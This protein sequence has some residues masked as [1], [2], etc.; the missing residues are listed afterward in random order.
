MKQPCRITEGGGNHFGNDLWKCSV[1][2]QEKYPEVF[3]CLRRYPTPMLGEPAV[4]YQQA[5][6]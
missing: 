4:Q 6:E 1:C 2:G 3:V 5:A